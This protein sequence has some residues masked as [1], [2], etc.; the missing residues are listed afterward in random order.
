MTYLS[1]WKGQ[2][3]APPKTMREIATRVAAEHGLTLDV[4]KAYDGRPHVVA[5]RRAAWQA[6][7]ATGRFS[8]PQIGRFFGRDHSTVHSAVCGK[9]RARA[10]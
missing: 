2:I 3:P 5:A 7:Y 1:L 10:A 9:R 8:Y 4:L 6:I